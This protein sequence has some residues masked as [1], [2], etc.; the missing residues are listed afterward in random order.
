MT[1]EKM[2]VMETVND[3]NNGIDVCD[4]IDWNDDMV[5]A[6]TE[7]PSMGEVGLIGLAAVGLGCAGYGLYKGGKWVVGKIKSAVDKRK[8][9]KVV[10]D[11]IIDDS[12]MNDTEDIK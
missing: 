4:T 6:T 8:A 1:E 10:D 2:E 3:M 11:N 7:K 12:D 5:P 9:E